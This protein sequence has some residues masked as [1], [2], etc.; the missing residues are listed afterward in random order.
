MVLESP[1]SSHQPFLAH[2][3]GSWFEAFVESNQYDYLITRWAM[4]GVDY[5]FYDR[6]CPIFCV[7]RIVDILPSTLLR[8]VSM[9]NG[10]WT[11]YEPSNVVHGK[12]LTLANVLADHHSDIGLT[13]DSITEYF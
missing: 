3:A 13:Y 11:F 1:S 10:T 8:T 7:Y 2:F 5:V 12:D 6:E 9:S 4:N